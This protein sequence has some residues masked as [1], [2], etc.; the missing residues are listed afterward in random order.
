MLKT[1]YFLPQVIFQSVQQRATDSKQQLKVHELITV[2]RNLGTTL[3]LHVSALRHRKKTKGVC[4]TVH[5]K[6]KCVER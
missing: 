2:A 4:N 6:V 5:K 3:K 1:Y